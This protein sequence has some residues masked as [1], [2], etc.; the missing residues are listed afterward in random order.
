MTS[1]VS[2]EVSNT[3]RTYLRKSNSKNISISRDP[4][5]GFEG[6]QRYE[7]R[8]PKLPSGNYIYHFIITAKGSVS[9]LSTRPKS[10][11]TRVKME[12]LVF[13]FNSLLVYFFRSTN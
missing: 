11:K 4:L 12:D 3:F 5:E 13:C 2:I 7:K 9:A 6:V 1:Q 10:S 8:E